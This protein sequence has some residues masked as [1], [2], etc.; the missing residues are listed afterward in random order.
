M[1]EERNCPDETI[2]IIKGETMLLF[3]KESASP[4]Q[5]GND[6]RLSYSKN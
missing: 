3:L 6:E 1:M 5:G 2:K 4:P